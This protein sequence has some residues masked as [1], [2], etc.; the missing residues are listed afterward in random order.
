MDNYI[1]IKKGDSDLE[2]TINLGK[3]INK[4]I[5]TKNGAVFGKVKQIRINANSYKIEGILAKR[6]LFKK[7]HYIG[8]SYIN[9]ITQHSIILNIDP[10]VLLRGR[11]VIDFNG[12]FVGRVKK[13]IRKGNTNDIKEI[14]V[15]SFLYNDVNIDYSKINHMG[16]SIILIKG[17]NAEKK[18]IWSRPDKRDNI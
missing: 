10:S 11:K 5:I 12:K 4:R 2:T 17:Y 8:F 7:D 1:I 18:R 3:I 9:K 15:E 13:V 14:I 16:K 6:S